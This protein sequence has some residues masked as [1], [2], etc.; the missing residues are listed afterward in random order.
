M[1]RAERGASPRPTTL[2]LLSLAVSASCALLGIERVPC[3]VDEDCPSNTACFDERC[4]AE[5]EGEGEGAGEGEGEGEGEFSSCDEPRVLVEGE[6]VALG[7]GGD[8]ACTGTP[9]VWRF[10]VPEGVATLELV[11]TSEV[12]G[13]VSIRTS[14]E[15]EATSLFCHDDD[16]G[17]RVVDVSPGGEIDVLVFLEADAPYTLTVTLRGAECGDGVLSRAIEECEDGNIDPGDGCDDDCTFE[18]I[19]EIEPNDDGNVQ[20][21]GTAGGNDFTMVDAQ[22][23]FFSDAVIKAELSPNGDEDI[24]TIRNPG[25]TQQRVTVRTRA[26]IQPCVSDSINVDTVL[27][28]RAQTGLAIVGPIDDISVDDLCSE[29]S[30][31]VQPQSTISAQV[32]AAGDTGFIEYVLDIDFE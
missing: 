29:A 1:S 6:N 2:A 22:G 17:A 13:A 25:D 3:V 19:D 23:P 12:N 28:L 5:G 14:C 16:D 15:D 8:G 20:T 27:V 18:G 21:G 24:F 31:V 10:A 30:F 26:R 7:Q 4:I 11:V 9:D 32:L